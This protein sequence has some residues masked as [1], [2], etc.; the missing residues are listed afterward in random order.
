MKLISI[1]LS[2]YAARVRI[3]IHA[4]G[5]PVEIVSP[6]ADWRTSAE[7]RK[8]NPL[9]RIPVLLLDDGTALAES[10]V[11]VEYLE[12]AYPEVPLRPRSPK[13][14]A[15]VRFVTQVTEQYVMTSMM[16]LFGLLDTKTPDEAA[17]KAQLAKLDGAMKQLN[18]LLQPGAYAV[19][20]RLTTADVWLTPVRYVLDGLMNFSGRKDILD[21]RY[22]ALLAYGEV[23]RR[24]PHAGR[25]LSEM[26][27]AYK[28]FMASRAAKG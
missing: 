19:G 28:E 5:L 1:A 16:P 26:D 10:G 2:P 22:P 13:E 25:V 21:E 24:D 23:A 18:G 9:V 14:A 3:A 4:K 17:I 12:D 8:L 6:P 11:I 15:R 27:Q 20:D 7:F